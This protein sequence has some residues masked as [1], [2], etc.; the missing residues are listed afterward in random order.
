MAKQS[1]F[2][3]SL[4]EVMVETGRFEFRKSIAGY[5]KMPEKRR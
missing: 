1:R 4:P 3:R 2:D 5:L